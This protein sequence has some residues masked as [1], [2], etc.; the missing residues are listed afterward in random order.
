LIERVQSTRSAITVA[1]IVGYAL[2]NSR[3]HGSTAF[4]IDAT[5]VR[6][7]FGGASEANAAHTVFLAIPPPA[8]SGRRQAVVMAIVAAVV[9]NG[10]RASGRRAGR[11]Q[12]PI[13]LGGDEP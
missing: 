7:S 13:M 11:P 4:T 6:S 5:G 12:P 9:A 3:I 8:R 1:G 2:S 10:G